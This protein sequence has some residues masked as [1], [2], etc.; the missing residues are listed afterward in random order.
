[1]VKGSPGALTVAPP[2]DYW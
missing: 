2:L 1:C